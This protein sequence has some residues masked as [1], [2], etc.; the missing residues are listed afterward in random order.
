MPKRASIVTV[1]G[2][3]RQRVA[4]KRAARV[5]SRVLAAVAMLA[6][7]VAVLAMWT[8]PPAS[9][10]GAHRAVVHILRWTDTHW[11]NAVAITAAGTIMTAIIPLVLSRRGRGQRSPGGAATGKAGNVP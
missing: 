11:L 9:L 3:I 2:R 1:R 5:L 4:G 7:V 8:T 10:L 6:L